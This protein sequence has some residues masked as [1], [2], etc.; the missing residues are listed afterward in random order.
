MYQAITKEQLVARLDGQCSPMR[1]RNGYVIGPDIYGRICH[2]STH[3]TLG[4]AQKK[5]RL[6]N[7]VDHDL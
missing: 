5:A 3:W 2:C 4:E 1:D 7:E 6:L